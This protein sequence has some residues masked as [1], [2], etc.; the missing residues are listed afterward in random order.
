MRFRNTNQNIVLFHFHTLFIFINKVD[1]SAFS[2]IHIII[3]SGGNCATSPHILTL[4]S[5]ND[6]VA[7]EFRNGVGGSETLR[8]GDSASDVNDRAAAFVIGAFIDAYS[9]AGFDLS[10]LDLDL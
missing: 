8:R 7:K 1:I 6:R 5:T 9:L 4:G 2:D 3:Q 10:T